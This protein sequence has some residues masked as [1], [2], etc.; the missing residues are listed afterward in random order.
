MV[1]TLLTDYQRL[2]EDNSDDSLFYKEARFVYHLDKSFRSRLSSLYKRETNNSNVILDLMSSW[3][4]H[5][6]SDLK[7]KEVIGHGLNQQELERNKRLDKFWV[8]DFN[9]EQSLPLADCSIDICL[10]TASWQYLQYP[11]PL[12]IEIKRVMRPKGKF[13]ISFSNRAFWTKATR[14]WIDSSDEERLNYISDV[15]LSN[16]WIIIQQIYEGSS[17][18]NLLELFRAKKDPFLSVI[19]MK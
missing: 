1:V 3:D 4:T 8:Q 15:L 14:K 12:A 5:L 2:K 10:M 17:T 18:N 16:G 6:P 7:Y 9:K 19:A 11:E 13:I